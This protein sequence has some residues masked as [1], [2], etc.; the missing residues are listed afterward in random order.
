MVDI[1]FENEDPPNTL[2]RRLKVNQQGWKARFMDKGD[3]FKKKFRSL[4][5]G[6]QERERNG[7]ERAV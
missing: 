5:L 2:P 7:G 4:L 3:I 1:G 6:L